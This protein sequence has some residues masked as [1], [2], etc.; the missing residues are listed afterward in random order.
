MK[1]ACKIFAPWQLI[2][3]SIVTC[4]LAC[5]NPSDPVVMT[6]SAHFEAIDANTLSITTSDQAV[7]AWREFSIAEHELAQ[8]VQPSAQSVVIN[9][10]TSEL[11]SALMGSLKANGKVFL[12]NPNGV[13]IGEK[14]S[15]DTNGFIASTLAAPIEDLLCG[16]H[17]AL[18]EGSSTASIVNLGKI[19]AWDGDVFLISYQVDNKGSVNAPSGTVALAAGQEVLLR[20]QDLEKIVIRPSLEKYENETTGLDNSGVITACKAELKSDGNAY[21]MAIKHTG[22]IDAL[23][24]A[25]HNGEI[26]LVAEDGNNGVYG[27]ITAKNSDGTGGSVQ[28]L[29]DHVAILEN[30]KIDASGEMGGGTIL[31]GGDK[32]G[33]NAKVLNAKTT[34]VDKN[35]VI[36]ANA[37]SDGNGG[38]VILWADE[39]TCF[40]G[41]IGVRGGENSGDGGFVEVSGMH[42]LDFRGVADRLAPQGNAGTLLLDPLDI[43]ISA[44]ADQNNTGFSP[45]QPTGSPSNLNTGTLIAALGGGP[46]IVQT[47]AGGV[48]VGNI[49]VSPTSSVLDQIVYNS[50]FNLTLDNTG[51]SSAGSA[52]TINP[53]SGFGPT[54]QNT[55]SGNVI[56]NS[57]FNTVINAPINLQGNM[58]VTTANGNFNMNGMTQNAD[59]VCNNFTGTINGQVNF[60]G[61][62]TVNFE[63]GIKASGTVIVNAQGDITLQGGG[64]ISSST[65]AY[66]ASSAGPV[67]VT[68]PTNLNLRTGTLG[69][70][71]IFS[72]TN[73]TVTVGGD[74]LMDTTL[75]TNNLGVASVIGGVNQT[76]VS[77]R[78]VT[79]TIG[80]APADIQTF[81]GGVSPTTLTLTGDLNIASIPSGGAG[82]GLIGGAVTVTTPGNVIM[83]GPT[84][85]LSAGGPIITAQTGGVTINA[86]NLTMNAPVSSGQSTI[87]AQHGPITINT[88]QAITLT[89]SA[90]IS[91]VPLGTPATQPLLAIA[92]TNISIDTNSFI[93]NQT[94]AGP[95][96][97][98]VDNASP[99]NVPFNIGPGQFINL[100]SIA[101]GTVATPGPLR[102]FTARRA[103][104]TQTGN[105]NGSVFSPGAFDVNTNTEVWRTWYPNAFFG[106]PNYT[107]FYKEPVTIPPPPPVP[108]PHTTQLAITLFNQAAYEFLQSLWDYDVFWY[109]ETDFS[110]DYA[111]EAYDSVHL[112]GSLETSNIVGE[113][114]YRLLRKSYKEQ[115]GKVI[116]LFH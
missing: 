83:T 14:G 17:E 69:Q 4:S 92:G 61:G 78:N 28:I 38:K 5:A 84:V 97:L 56:I 113:S 9:K 40:Y 35:A 93:S 1:K 66:I 57:G 16:T 76:L 115:N 43:D 68:T 109:W 30:A 54:I 94:N 25:E 23:G 96:T 13:L 70:A 20:P 21:A 2:A 15:I 100:G 8:F 89:N 64:S 72:G 74:I 37:R 104:N 107:I 36:T 95:V 60:T 42:S 87:L 24:V 44:A 62:N 105:L 114:T 47:I 6:G 112:K 45:F 98:V 111:H 85:A 11:S 34:Y 52:I 39:T 75:S 22:T 101:A 67:T 55:G 63:T 46:V 77:A 19:T 41:N 50:P 82:S 49:T 18:F 3:F 58:T 71:N 80:I 48:S 31:I 59:I 10:V 99:F 102:V 110:A 103:Q 90:N 88:T 29:G 12:L 7:I 51:A 27:S 91:I 106:G 33:K 86:N 108:P 73:A 81:S 32:N 53:T 65:G 79:M 116:S 26:F